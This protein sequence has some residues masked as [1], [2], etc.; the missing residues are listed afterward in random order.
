MRM[1]KFCY[2]D[3]TTRALMNKRSHF[4]RNIYRRRGGQ[5]QRLFLDNTKPWK[6]TPHNNAAF[7]VWH[8]GP[9]VTRSEY[10]I[11]SIREQK[12]SRRAGYYIAC[13]RSTRHSCRLSAT[14]LLSRFRAIACRARSS[15]L[16][17]FLVARTCK[18]DVR[19][20]QREIISIISFLLFAINICTQT[21]CQQKLIKI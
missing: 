13:F 21:V 19:I 16:F 14:A 1:Q 7:D 6:W 4:E 9:L 17:I 12:F 5:P 2:F 20:F 18:L 3:S 8:D 15:F 10:L 11:Y